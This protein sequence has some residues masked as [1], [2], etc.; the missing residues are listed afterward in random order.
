MFDGDEQSFQ[1]RVTEPKENILNCCLKDLV[2]SFS[3]F[4]PKKVPKVSTYGEYRAKAL[5]EHYGSQLAA[6]SVL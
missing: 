4:D 3:I 1:C 5:S 2:P 6:E